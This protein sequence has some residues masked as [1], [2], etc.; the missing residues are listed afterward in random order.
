M[1]EGRAFIRD[2][3]LFSRFREAGGFFGVLRQVGG[4]GWGAAAESM[5]GGFYFSGAAG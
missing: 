5:C 1:D 3:R 2:A 4:L